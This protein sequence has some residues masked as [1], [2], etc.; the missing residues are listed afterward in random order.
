MNQNSLG[1]TDIEHFHWSL[2]EA[3][4]PRSVELENKPVSVPAAVELAIIEA[5]SRRGLATAPTFSSTNCSAMYSAVKSANWPLVD[6]AISTKSGDTTVVVLPASASQETGWWTKQLQALKE[7]L[8]TNGFSSKLAGALTGGVGEMVDN[9]WSHSFCDDPALL[10]YQ[11]RTKKFA[12]SVA[13][14]G[15]GVLESLRKN[16]QYDFLRSSMEAISF[17]I[18]PGV[19]RLENGGMGFATM[20]KSMAELWGNARIRS[21]E[22]ALIVDRTQETAVKNLIYLPQL[23]GL[24]VSARCSLEAPRKPLR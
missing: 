10:V 11:V 23:P 9:A 2:S 1:V 20:L 13:D 7:D 18:E 17:A 19:S 3:D 5:N 22:A 6:K 21:G 14:L 16:P 4:V 15:V 12:F 24:H 8:V